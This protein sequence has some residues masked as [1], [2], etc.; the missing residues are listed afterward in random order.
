[1]KRAVLNLMRSTGLFAPFRLANRN[2]ALIVVYHR[3]SEN[4]DRLATSA[5]ALREQLEYLIAHYRVISLTEM[6]SYFQ[7]GKRLPARVAA[8]TVDDGYRDCFE[9]AFP[10]LREYGLPASVFVATDFI[11]Q[12]TWLWTDKLRYLTSRAA[13]ETLEATINDRALRI[14]LGDTE[15]RLVAASVVNSELKQIPDEVK[16]DII[17]SLASS[18]NVQLPYVPPGEFSPLTWEQVREMDAAG[19]E[20]GSHT[21][22]HPILTNICR[23]RLRRELNDSRRRL[24]EVLRR[25]VDLFC[26]P[27]GDYDRMVS[28][29]V[30]RAGY[31]CA[32]T[33]RHGLNTSD[34]DPL[35]LRRIH[36]ERDIVHFV[37][38]T[39]GF[40]MLKNRLRGTHPSLIAATAC[41]YLPEL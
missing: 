37:Q 27:N 36:T 26:Y 5:R 41:E 23:D 13:T 7:R 8:I 17:T 39:S 16:D 34:A 24:E 12:R 30:E 11:D 28:S 21:L 14:Q 32:V 15:S 6:A 20:I 4:G 35:A 3:F 40:E 18:L 22:T 9:I 33:S 10:L 2:K 38:S 29:E 19:V 25:K 1:M 31:R